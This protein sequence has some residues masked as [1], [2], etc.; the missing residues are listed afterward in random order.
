MIVDIIKRA[1]YPN[2]NTDNEPHAVLARLPFPLY[3]TTNYDDFMFKALENANKFPSLFVNEWNH[4]KTTEETTVDIDPSVGNPAVYHFHGH[5]DYIN[6]IVL[7]EDDYLDFL[8]K[9]SKDPNLIPP[10]IQ[11]ALAGTQLLFIGY[12]LGDINFRV[13]FRGL[14]ET[15]KRNM[16]RVSIAVQLRPDKP[17]VF[18]YLTEYFDASNIRVFWGTAREFVAE[19]ECRWSKLT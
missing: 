16:R 1:G 3:M 6:S 14:V 12:S 5:K 11:H 10:R 17:E 8:V 9:I 19:L 2:F 15:L 7:T 18:Q 4:E 13:I